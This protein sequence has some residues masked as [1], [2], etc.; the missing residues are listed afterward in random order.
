M[1]LSGGVP[2]GSGSFGRVIKR[3]F[4]GKEVAAKIFKGRED[5]LR[6]VVAHAAFSPHV[7]IVRLVDVVV[8]PKNIELIYP[9]FDSTLGELLAQRARHPPT[10]GFPEEQRHITQML[11]HTVAHLHSH[12]VIHTDIKS[13]NALVK[14]CGC[15]SYGDKEDLDSFGRRLFQLPAFLQVCL[16][17]VGSLEPADPA[18]RAHLSEEQVKSQGLRVGRDSALPGP[19]GGPGRQRVL[20]PSGLLGLGMR[21]GGA[22]SQEALV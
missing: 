19:G 2:L 6:E 5:A 16:A 15:A 11:V 3:K 9:L 8:G 20:L 17:D 1:D 12:H 13:A 10:R 14:G 4:K 21:S 18:H 7:G 22:H